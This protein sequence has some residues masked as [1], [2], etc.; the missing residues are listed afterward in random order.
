MYKRSSAV[1]SL[2]TEINNNI[3]TVDWLGGI[4]Q[5]YMNQTGT[6]TGKGSELPLV[7]SRWLWCLYEVGLIEKMEQKNPKTLI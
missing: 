4:F 1:A 3:I 7:V 5:V 2:N 6:E